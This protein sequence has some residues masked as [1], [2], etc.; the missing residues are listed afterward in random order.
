MLALPSSIHGTIQ[1]IF[2]YHEY[3]D[4]VGDEQDIELM[5]ATLTGSITDY[6]EGLQLTNW[7]PR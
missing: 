3:E 2:T 1:S 4:D 7:E 6:A 5:G